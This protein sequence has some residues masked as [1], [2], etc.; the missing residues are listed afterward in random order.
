MIKTVV[1]DL[2][3]KFGANFVGSIHNYDAGGDIDFILEFK[4]LTLN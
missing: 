3:T 4:Q 1:S 2:Q